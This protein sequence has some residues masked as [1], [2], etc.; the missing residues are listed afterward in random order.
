MLNETVRAVANDDDYFKKRWLYVTPRNIGGG[1]NS[2]PFTMV[3]VDKLGDKILLAMT[4]YD[5]MQL[6]MLISQAV[7]RSSPEYQQQAKEAV[8]QWRA[9][10]SPKSAGTP[11]TEVESIAP[12]A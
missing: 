3:F 8:A 6:S 9:S 10:H 12:G 2:D 7:E 5:L 11:S 4:E 1:I